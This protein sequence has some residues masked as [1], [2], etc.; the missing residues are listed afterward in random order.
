MAGLFSIKKEPLILPK[1]FKGW[2]KCLFYDCPKYSFSKPNRIK[3]LSDLGRTIRLLI[4]VIVTVLLFLL[5]NENGHLRKENTYIHK[6]ESIILIP[7]FRD[8]EL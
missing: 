4:L 5:A 3:F 8:K 6:L 7:N 2:L 1:S